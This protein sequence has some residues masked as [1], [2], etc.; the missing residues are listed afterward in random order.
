MGKIWLEVFACFMHIFVE[1]GTNNLYPQ[2]SVIDFTEEK[3]LFEFRFDDPSISTY[4]CVL[5][6]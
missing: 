4:R 1:D 2:F 3:T 5:C 6:P